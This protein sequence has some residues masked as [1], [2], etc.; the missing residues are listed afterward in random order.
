MT[1]ATLKKRKSWPYCGDRGQRVGSEKTALEC[2]LSPTICQTISRGQERQYRA[3]IQ[4]GPCSRDGARRCTIGDG[5]DRLGRSGHGS[6]GG[7]RGQRELPNRE[8]TDSKRME[9]LLDW[10]SQVLK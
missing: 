4:G 10:A 1:L 7:Q 6:V 9:S 2:L 8:R 5:I 3:P